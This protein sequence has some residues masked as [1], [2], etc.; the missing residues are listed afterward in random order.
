MENKRSGLMFWKLIKSFNYFS[1]ALAFSSLY[2]SSK[3]KKKRK[4]ISNL[5]AHCFFFFFLKHFILY[6]HIADWQYCDSFRWTAKQLSHR[7]IHQIRSDQSLSRVWL[8]A[9][10]WIAARQASLSIT[11]SRSSLRL[12]SIESVHPFTPKLPSHPAYHITLNRVP[13][14]IP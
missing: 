8:F 5:H 7:Y 6:L 14:T 13:C 2:L 10:P 9:T 11:N 12:T 3:F 1:G 4:Y